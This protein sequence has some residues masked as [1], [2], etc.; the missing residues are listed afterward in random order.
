M[1]QEL[2]SHKWSNDQK[3]LQSQYAPQRRKD[4]ILWKPEDTKLVIK[5]QKSQDLQ[6]K[7]V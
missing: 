4:D 5:T 6:N 7:K 1:S 3:L 2:I